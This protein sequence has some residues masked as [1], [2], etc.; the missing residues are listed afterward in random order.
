MQKNNA[1]VIFCTCPDAAVAER[2]AT[3]LVTDGL[4]AC[5]NILPAMR[6]VFKWRGAVENASEHMLIVKGASSAYPAI[7]AYLRSQHPYELPEIIAVSVVAGLPA[8]LSW[9]TNPDH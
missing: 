2:L 4:A 3:G 7:E 6:S 9:L 8:Y 1:Q 5:V